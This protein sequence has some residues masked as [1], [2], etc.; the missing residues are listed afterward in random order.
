MSTQFEAL[1]AEVL[2][3]APADRAL[4]AEH[5]IASLDE[6]SEIAAAWAAEV[7]RRVAEVESGAV[8]GMPCGEVI[9]QAR[10]AK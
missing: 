8:V 6:D 4:L 9:A 10:A 1:E 3:L 7:E 2:K 5:L